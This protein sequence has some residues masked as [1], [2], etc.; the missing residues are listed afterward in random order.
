MR[1]KRLLLCAVTAVFWFSQYIYVPYLTPYLMAMQLTA[2]AAGAVL[3]AYGLSQMIVRIPL[4]LAADGLRRH[5][6]VIGCGLLLAASAALMMHFF[7]SVAMMMAARTVAGL[8]SATW[9]SFTVLFASYYPPEEGGR[10]MGII[11][12]MNQSGVLAGYVLG[13]FLVAKIG[14]NGLFLIGGGVAIAGAVLSLFLSEEKV[15]KTPR[16]PLRARVAV[17]AGKRLILYALLA[18]LYQAIVFATVQSFTATVAKALGASDGALAL[19]SGLFTAGSIAGSWAIS[20]GRV[21]AAGP[22]WLTAIGFTGMALYALGISYAG[23]L[24]QVMAMQAFGGLVGAGLFAYLMA[25]AVRG[26]DQDRKASAMGFYQSVYALG[27]TFGPPVMGTIVASLGLPTA[28]RAVA[29]LAIVAAIA[30]IGIGKWDKGR[31]LSC[32]SAVRR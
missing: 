9:I 13:G 7:D 19:C 2:S 17:F 6:C 15:E 21:R 28:Y 18:A 10:A 8:A 30:G 12:A 31:E 14:V 24:W 25:Q 1:P 4:G 27:M 26:V 20:T 16:V 32:A 23:K 22:A 11:N 3:G 5:K 29:A